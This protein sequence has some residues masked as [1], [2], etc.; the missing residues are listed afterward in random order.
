MLHVPKLQGLM[1]FLIVAA[2]VVGLNAAMNQGGMLG[3]SLYGAVT[4]TY[5]LLKILFSLWYRPFEAPEGW[6]DDQ[7]VAV[8]VP[9]YNEDL[10]VFQRCLQSILLQSRPID[11]IYVVDDG[12]QDDACFRVAQETFRGTPH[13]VVRFTENRGKR[14]AQE[15]AFRE[16]TADIVLTVDSDSVLDENAVRE[17]LKPFS[18]TSV[19][20]VCGQ[21]RVL[22]RDQNFLTRLLDLRYRNS[23]LYERTAYT[24]WDSVLCSSGVISFWRV[25]LVRSHLDDYVN[26]TFLGVPVG[27]GDDRRMTNYALL[28][29]RVVFQETAVAD[30]VVPITL[31]HFLKQQNRWNKSFFRETIFALTRLPLRRIAWWISLS[32]VALWLFFTVNLVASVIRPLVGGTALGVYYLGYLALMA[33]ARNVRFGLGNWGTFLLSPLYGALHLFLLVPLRVLSLFSLR[34]GRWGTREAGGPPP[35]TVGSNVSSA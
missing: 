9:V 15:V 24:V 19:Q 10:E 22:N 27:Y 34:D 17:G 18:M 11:E 13:R 25:A 16:T 23:F 30:T 31:R 5:L 33:Y 29:G 20:G 14:Y 28:T 2:A 12:S 32:E 7:S 26:Q 1:L 35:P 6:C 4:L 3:F 8:I 21:V